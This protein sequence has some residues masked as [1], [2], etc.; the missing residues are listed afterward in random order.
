MSKVLIFADIHINAHKKS[1]ERLNDCLCVLEWVFATAKKHKIEN[2]IFAGDLFQDRQK[3]DVITYSKTFDILLKSCTGD[4]N[5]Y[6]LLGNNDLWYHDKWDVSSV[7]PFSALPSVKV[8]AK[9]STEIIDEIPVYFLPYTHDPINHLKQLLASTSDKHLKTLVGH[10]ACHGATLNSLYNTYSDVIIEHDGE[11]VQVGEEVFEG[12]DKVWLGH[13]HCPQKIGKNIEYIG[14]P[15]QLT[16][17]EAFQDKHLIIYDLNNADAT[18]IENTFSPK[19]IIS[20]E[21]DIF[22]H[23]IGNN[24]IRINA[25]IT[26]KTELI[27]FKKN[28]EKKLPSTLEILPY[29][30][31][32]EQK[33]IVDKAKELLQKEDDMLENYVKITDTG[34]LDKKLLMNVVKKIIEEAQKS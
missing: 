23:D 8:I 25:T 18:Y 28:I 24:F 20:T 9:P 1:Y 21:E 32:D 14:S 15:L 22:K 11:M 2:I 19:H 17:G 33:Q 4:F 10:L 13:Y 26:S 7:L 30:K 29:Q 6:L 5:L 12:W 34:D 31:K 16:F 3:I 27:D